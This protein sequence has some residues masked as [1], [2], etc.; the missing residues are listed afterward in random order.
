MAE[1]YNSFRK[2]RSGIE[3]GLVEVSRL[4][5]SSGQADLEEVLRIVGTAV[6]AEC[7]YLVTVLDDAPLDEA[8]IPIG[9]VVK[10]HRDGEAAKERL[11]NGSPSPTGPAM[12]LLA[13]A[14]HSTPQGNTLHES[15]SDGEQAG[16]AIPLLSRQDRFVGYLGIE[17]AALS[18]EELREHGRVL[19]VFGDLLAGYLDRTRAEHALSE[20]EERWRKF[21]EFNP[22]AIL[23]L[24]DNVILYANEAC[25]RLFGFHN[26]DELRS[27]ALRDFLPADQYEAVEQ[28]RTEHVDQASYTPFEHEIIRLDGDERVVETVAVGVPFEGEEAVQMVI[29]DI[30]DRRRSE[31]R[32][33]NFVQTISEGVWRIDLA[34]PVSALALPYLQ[35]DRIFHH[36]YLAE[37][38]TMM[39]RLLGAT[40]TESVVGKP[41]HTLVPTLDERT[42]H[43]F[44]ED[45][46]RLH[47]HEL[48]VQGEGEPRHFALN[49]VGRLE[50]GAL[51][52]IWGSC[53]EVTERVE[54]ER[55]MVAVLEEQQERIGRDL[56]DSVGQLLTGIRMLSEN[57][58][59]RHFEPSAPG[60]AAT[61]KVT[62]FA[63][64]ALQRVREICRGLVPPQLYQEGLTSAL[65]ALAA[66]IDSLSDVRCIFV[67]Q[68]TV[69]IEDYDAKLQL[70]RMTQEA[71]NNAM[72]H[73]EPSHVW[74]RFI[75]THEQFTLEIEDDGVGFDVESNL[76][77]SLGLYSM[78]R[79]ASSIRATLTIDSE[80][81]VGTMVRAVLPTHHR[82]RG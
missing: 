21:V 51:V 50:R 54:M 20:S 70:Y 58:A 24:S 81:G 10:W 23:V 3:H 48:T 22:E 47:N 31:E 64:E 71:I 53:V 18:D 73:A 13:Q 36:G 32:Y 4:L 12:R 52:R 49:A 46:Y 60:H 59:A 19:S 5:V 65:R 44:I 27:Y 11:F 45:G 37:C 39:T 67:H 57:L 66:N 33:R 56:H 34:E 26:P 74:I 8:S 38:N 30:T 2:H 25:A 69:D 43:T 35:A 42:I 6:G 40:R 77:K 17:H 41:L 62:A 55:R 15:S 14:R 79:R 72:K 1:S 75:H 78:K 28:Q 63:E 68:G 7:A 9:Q 61:R 76:G 29:R 80:P 16:L 82:L